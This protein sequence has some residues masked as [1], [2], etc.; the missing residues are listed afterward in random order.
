MNYIRLSF[1]VLSMLLL[2][3][4]SVILTEYVAIEPRVCV[5]LCVCVCVCLCIFVCFCEFII[6]SIV[7]FCLILIVIMQWD[8]DITS[9][10]VTDIQCSS[11]GFQVP[12]GSFQ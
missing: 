4:Y 11:H 7:C 1:L 12:M 8:P 3:L 5:C 10:D 6:C 9:S 2:F